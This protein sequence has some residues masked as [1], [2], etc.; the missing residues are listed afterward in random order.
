VVT[1]YDQIEHASMTDVGMRRSHNQ[2]RHAVLLASDAQQ[3]QDRGHVFLVADGMGG[4][5]VGE[6]AADMAGD[7]IPHI[8]HKHAHQGPDIALRTAILEAN[9]SIHARG[10]QNREFEGMG[11]TA[12]ALLI[13]PEGAWVAHVGDSRT[14]RVRPDKIEQL[15]FD[16][17]WL[18]EL[19]RRQ[20]V[21]PETLKHVPS[22]RILRCLGSDPLVQVDID[23]PYPL[24]EGDIFVVCSDGLSGQVPDEEIGAAANAL[25]PAEACEFLTHLANLRG[26]PDNI[27]TIIVRVNRSRDEA[28]VSAPVGRPARPWHQTVPWQLLSLLLGLLLASFALLL[29]ITDRRYVGFVFVLAATSLLV[30]LVGLAVMYFSDPGPRKDRPRRGRPKVYRQRSCAVT[31]SML[32]KL[33]ESSATLQALVRDRNWHADWDTYSRHADRAERCLRQNDLSSAYREYCLAI[34]PLTEAFHTYCHRGDSFK[35]LWETPA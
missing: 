33:I 5:A 15:T 29:S 12:T 3:W 24:E 11:T 4:H 2:D 18:W 6:M 22:N 16:H 32:D 20:G 8:Y 17:S 30:G 1:A 19:A 21:E 9:A 35:P 10:Q 26:G 34:R 28:A 25:P 7:I 13:R 27:T 23:G 31:R 14:Y